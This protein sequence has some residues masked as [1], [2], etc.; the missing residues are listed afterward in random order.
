[1]VLEVRI[2][3]DVNGDWPEADRRLYEFIT[4]NGTSSVWDIINDNPDLDGLVDSVAVTDFT[5]F[6]IRELSSGTMLR[7]CTARVEVLA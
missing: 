1:M 2:E 6:G 7:T 3:I 4:P 5:N